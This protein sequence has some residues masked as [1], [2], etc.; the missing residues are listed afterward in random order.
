[1]EEIKTFHRLALMFGLYYARIHARGLE[2]HR[3][4]SYTLGEAEIADVINVTREFF[5]RKPFLAN[6][7]SFDNTAF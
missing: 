6:T 3:Q 4:A 5:R 1:M 2:D 7:A